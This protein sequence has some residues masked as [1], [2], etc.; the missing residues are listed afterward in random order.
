VKA[1][2]YMNVSVLAPQPVPAFTMASTLTVNA[3]VALNGTTLVPTLG[4]IAGQVGSDFEQLWHG[5]ESFVAPLLTDAIR[6]VALPIA[7]QQLSSGFAIPTSGKMKLSNPDS[8][9]QQ[10]LVGCCK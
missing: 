7:N 10:Q 1:L 6:Y 8:A 5:W 4:W 3:T 2:V 9:N